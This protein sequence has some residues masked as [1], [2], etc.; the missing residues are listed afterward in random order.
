MEYDFDVSIVIPTLNRPELVKRC[1]ISISNQTLSKDIQC[2]IVD[3]SIGTETENAISQLKDLSANI[4][5]QYYKNL[6]SKRPIDNWIFSIDKI[7]GEFAKFICDDDWLEPTFLEESLNIFNQ[8]EVDCVI[9]NIKIHK[10][11]S[12]LN[13]VVNN[14]YFFEEGIV[15]KSIVIDSILGLSGM[16]PVTPTAN[17]MKTKALVDSFNS[18]LD[19][20]SCT[21]K[22]FGFD[23]HM[24]YFPVFMLKGTY[25][26]SKSLCNSWAGED[27]MTL[28]VKKSNIAYCYLFSLIRL[29]ELSGF[30]VNDKQRENIENKLANI[31]IKSLFNND[32][33]NIIIDSSFR[34]KF[35]LSKTVLKFLKKIFIK[36]KYK[37]K[38]KF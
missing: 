2:I 23:F 21:E 33:K 32:I 24:S 37:I 20:I 30:I 13:E 15:D 25:L 10:N 19:H 1:I 14:Y 28:N 11:F 34:T 3:S 31:K 17:L 5:V 27:S 18:S 22:L 7:K 38:N 26:L 29:I 9:S 36:V 16:L 8:Y 35:N 6:E 12:N 4:T